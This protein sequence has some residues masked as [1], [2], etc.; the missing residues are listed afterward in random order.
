MRAVVYALQGFLAATTT[1][2]TS[3]NPQYI[4]LGTDGTVVEADPSLY[5]QSGSNQPY[6]HRDQD[7]FEKKPELVDLAKPSQ[8]E[9]LSGVTLPLARK[10]LAETDLDIFN[11]EADD[12]EFSATTASQET[13]ASVSRS[14]LALINDGVPGVYGSVVFAELSCC[15]VAFIGYL[16]RS[17]PLWVS[18]SR[19]QKCCL[20]VAFSVALLYQFAAVGWFLG[21]VTPELMLG[22]SSLI[23]RTISL[24]MVPI[25]TTSFMGRARIC[26]DHSTTTPAR[27]RKSSHSRNSYR[28]HTRAR[29]S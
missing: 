5:F 27:S 7:Q 18:F 25:T 24:G 17:I 23:T 6:Q 29:S 13:A 11:K 21:A 10:R 12:D 14:T 22:L 2:A 15:F 9:E 19:G 20:V 1:M 28:H 16:V 26:Q 3:Y 8:P 4:V